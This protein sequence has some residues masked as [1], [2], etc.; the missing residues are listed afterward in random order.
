MF[1]SPRQLFL[2]V[3]ELIDRMKTSPDITRKGQF[4]V[5]Y[6]DGVYSPRITYDVAKFHTDMI[7]GNIVY[8][9]YNDPKKQQELANGNQDFRRSKRNQSR[10][11]WIY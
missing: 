6:K 5:Y 4:R 9:R 11:Y 3:S 1:K 10:K 2:F 8:V 7:G